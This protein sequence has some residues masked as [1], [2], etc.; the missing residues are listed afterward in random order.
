MNCT[1]RERRDMAIYDPVSP[2]RGTSS[3]HLP[4][5]RPL[6]VRYENIHMS[7][8]CPCVPRGKSVHNKQPFIGSNSITSRQNVPTP[9][10]KHI[11]LP[12]TNYT[13]LPLDTP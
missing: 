3:V 13:L 10:I 11:L 1:L 12:V 9:L 8:G 7:F 6:V 5:V 2:L 4:C